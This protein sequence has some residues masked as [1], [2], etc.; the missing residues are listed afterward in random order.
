MYPDSSVGIQFYYLCKN[1]GVKFMQQH[2]S[3]MEPVRFFL[4]LMF[5]YEYETKYR[6]A[7]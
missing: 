7:N 5:K 6:I 1:V 2:I 3:G 4:H